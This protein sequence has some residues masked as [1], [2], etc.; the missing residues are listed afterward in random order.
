MPHGDERARRWLERGAVVLVTL[1]VILPQA[2][3]GPMLYDL[4]E[5]LLYTDAVVRGRLPG[6]DFVVNGYG[7]GRYVLLAALTTLGFSPLAAA[8]F[9]F[10]ALRVALSLALLSIGRRVLPGRWRFVPI[11]LVLL[12]PGPMHKG[13]FLL[14]TAMLAWFGLRCLDAPPSDRDRRAIELGACVGLVALFRLD[15]GLFGALLLLFLAAV[16]ARR[17]DPRAL[18]QLLLASGPPAVVLL[19]LIGLF[20]GL[21]T[22][23]PVLDQVLHDVL[24]NQR[25][26]WPA[27]PTPAELLDDWRWSRGLL[28][29]PALVL[30]TTAALLVRHGTPATWLV[31]FLALLAQ[32]QVRM[33]PELGHLFQAGPLLW[34]AAAWLLARLPRPAGLALLGGL[35]AWLTAA[36]AVEHPRSPYVGSFTNAF[37][38]SA[39]STPAGT[40][41]MTAEEEADLAPVLAWLERQPPGDALWVPANEPL[42]YALSGRPDV[43][44]VV[45]VLYVADDPERQQD[46]LDRVERARPSLAVVRDSSMEGPTRRLSVA[47]PS[48]WTYL[49]ATYVE[50]ERIGDWSLRRRKVE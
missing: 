47:A 35:L 29:L 24:V 15:L 41:R 39:H 10:L 6:V 37:V 11:A 46:L 7:P 26:P 44:G 28:W 49:D 50:A 1:A 43:V 33:K 21:G 17:G 36:I 45:G 3:P 27:F 2:N 9:V 8:T 18:R 19:G 40:L 14:G 38:R 25:V 48:V 31:L 34:V 16:G 22:L 4:G 23:G 20:V 42:L 13:F 32:N 30:L 5:L 12:A